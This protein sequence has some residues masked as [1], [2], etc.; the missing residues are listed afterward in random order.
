MARMKLL[1][2]TAFTKCF[3]NLI[4]WL[5]RCFLILSGRKQTIVKMVNHFII[6]KHY[7]RDA[8]LIL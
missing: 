1:T 7:S 8:L 5:C 4:V 6:Q 3:L 2:K